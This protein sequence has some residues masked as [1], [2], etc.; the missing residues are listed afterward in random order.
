MSRLV[1]N[2]IDNAK[3]AIVDAIKNNTP[4][5]AQALLTLILTVDG[6]GSGLDAD[7]LDGLEPSE[8]ANQNPEM[9][10]Q[11]A[12]GSRFLKLTPASGVASGEPPVIT[13]FQETDSGEP[14][15]LIIYQGNGVFTPNLQIDPVTPF[16]KLHGNEVWHAGN[17]D[18]NHI[19]GSYGGW[20]Y[21]EKSGIDGTYQSILPYT[22]TFSFIVEGWFK[23]GASFAK[24]DLD[25][26][27]TG[28]GD[29]QLGNIGGNILT[30]YFDQTNGM[31]VRRS[32]GT[33]TCIFSATI[34]YGRF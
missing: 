24:V 31:R 33:Q 32:D 11:S 25:V 10:V 18:P 13:M 9:Y 4:I 16:I 5:S 17:L 14:P 21:Y 3:K 20:I 6:T 27:A 28:G 19:D 15:I 23:T 8:V 2:A 29:W 34:K 30:L 22:D 7:L 12:G 1:A 26:Q